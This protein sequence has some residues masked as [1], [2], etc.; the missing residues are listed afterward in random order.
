MTNVV[1]FKPDTEE[2]LGGLCYRT[3]SQEEAYKLKCLPCPRCGGV[4]E[5]VFVMAAVSDMDHHYIE[6][7][8]CGHQDEFAFWSSS[9]SA[10]EHWNREILKK[11]D[12]KTD[13]RNEKTDPHLGFE[14]Y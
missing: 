5:C 9:Y 12:N 10:T 7:S 2:E 4:P 11:T 3:R 13:N 6:C 1:S 8:V 14:L